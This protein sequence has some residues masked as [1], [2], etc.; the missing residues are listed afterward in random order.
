MVFFVIEFSHIKNENK[1]NSLLEKQLPDYVSCR[2]E[3]RVNMLF[4]KLLGSD[5]LI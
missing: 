5:Q 4:L 3:I 1:K 2:R